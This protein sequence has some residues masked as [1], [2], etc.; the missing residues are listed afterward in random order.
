M[1]SE[2]N[3]IASAAGDLQQESDDVE[4]VVSKFSPSEASSG[5]H[6]LLKLEQPIKD[7]KPIPLPKPI[8][9]KPCP[10]TRSGPWFDPKIA[11]IRKSNKVRHDPPP[12]PPVSVMD[13]FN[14]LS[15]DK[16]DEADGLSIHEMSH[17]LSRINKYHPNMNMNKVSELR[18]KPSD[19]PHQRLIEDNEDN[20]G[21]EFYSYATTNPAYED[22][23]RLMKSRG[24]NK[25]ISDF[26]EAIDN[27]EQKSNSASSDSEDFST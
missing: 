4:S 26:A 10:P 13:D 20:N 6:V 18:E 12:I 27:T 3:G 2:G 23:I 19:D 9:I 21:G 14:N 11:V 22:D 1:S 15:N 5:S 24:N 17:S 25:I 7:K 16:R 8:E